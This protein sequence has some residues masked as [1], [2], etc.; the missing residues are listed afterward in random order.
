M[1]IAGLAVALA[2]A[3]IGGFFS[4]LGAW[5]QSRAQMAAQESLY[6]EDRAR[7]DREKRS[8]VYKRLLE[9]SNSFAV[10][11]DEIATDCSDRKCSPDW[12]EWEDARF[13]FQG[14]LNEVWIYGSDDAAAQAEVISTTLPESIGFPK[15]DELHIGVKSVEFAQAYSGFLALMCRE[16]PAVPRNGC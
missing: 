9:T 4:Y 13:E 16:L 3:L 15:P 8:E 7:E 10:A 14:A 6:R 5:Q 1:V 12:S 2:G 11:T